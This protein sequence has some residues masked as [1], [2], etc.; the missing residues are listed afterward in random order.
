VVTDVGDSAEI[1]G[2]TGTVVPPGDAEAFADALSE[3]IDLGAEARNQRGREAR[4]RITREFDVASVAARYEELYGSLP[5]QAVDIRPLEGNQDR[6]HSSLPLRGNIDRAVVQGFGDEWTRFDQRPLAE[7]DLRNMF[8]DFFSVFPWDALPSDAVG[9]D[10]GC[11]SGRW[12]RF[13]APHVGRLHCIDPSA[14]ALAVAKRS[15]SQHPNCLFH[16]A[17]IDDMP[18]TDCSMDFGYALGV[19][20]HLPDPEAGIESCV[21]KLK[22]GA[23]FLLYLYY[24]FDNRPPWFRLM[25]RLSNV[26]RQAISR[27]PYTLRYA[28]SQLIAGAVYYPWAR[29][30]LL[31]ERVGV[32]N[33]AL[34][35]LSWYRERSFYTMRT[36]ALDRFG[37]K[38]EKRFSAEEISNMMERAGLERI[39]FSHSMPF[40]CAVGY[41]KAVDIEQGSSGA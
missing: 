19:L 33:V 22:S 20:H 2:S 16:L 36:D 29:L 32:K 21:R 25:W 13:V 6:G 30:A 17:S 8:N 26:L 18:L 11:G 1:V 10:V 31:L 12:A 28:L 37:T 7:Q 23:P 34:F 9:F 27:S 40:W 4:A 3:L 24:A 38:L 35:P 15:L 41:K 39:A 14:P 5:R